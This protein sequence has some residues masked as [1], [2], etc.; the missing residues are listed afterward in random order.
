MRR[1][2]CG[3]PDALA[4]DREPAGATARAASVGASPA[5]VPAS[6]RRSTRASASQ[7]SRRAGAAGRAA[8]TSSIRRAGAS[9]RGTPGAASGRWPAPRRCRAPWMRRRCDAA[10]A[11][12]ADRDRPRDDAG[13][14]G[15]QHRLGHAG[16]RSRRSSSPNRRS[17]QRWTPLGDDERRGPPAAWGERQHGATA[18]PAGRDRHRTSGAGGR[19]AE[20]R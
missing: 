16:Q 18:L 10:A 15:E 3:L 20:P 9:P 14:S 12:H 2:T 11:R 19:P 8:S 4:S 17:S 7:P 5:T 13:G 6:T 1:C